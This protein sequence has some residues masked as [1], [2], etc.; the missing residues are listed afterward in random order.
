MDREE[1]VLVRADKGEELEEEEDSHG[2]GTM[3]GGRQSER[4]GDSVEIAEI[5]PLVSNWLMEKVS[6]K[7]KINPSG[8]K[9]QNTKP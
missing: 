8:I 7:V 3:N 9:L 5:P 4:V 1:K 2:T 6:S